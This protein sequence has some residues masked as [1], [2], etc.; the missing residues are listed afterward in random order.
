MNKLILSLV[1]VGGLSLTLPAQAND[2]SPKGNKKEQRK[3]MSPEERAKMETQHAEKKLSLTADQKPKW[4]SASLTRIKANQP[5]HEK[6]K[7]STTPEERK[8]LHKSIQG[9]N[10]AFDKSVNEFLTADQKTKWEAE[11]KER[12]DRRMKKMGGKGKPEEV[13]IHDGN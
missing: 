11:K 7:G 13:D 1:L 3:D 12:K 10:E 4:E 9:N 6:M 8:E 2:A 5:F